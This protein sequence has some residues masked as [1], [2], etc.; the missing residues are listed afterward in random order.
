VLASSQAVCKSCGMAVSERTCTRASTRRKSR[1]PANAASMVPGSTVSVVQRSP[2]ASSS[3]RCGVR[4]ATF[5]ACV[6]GASVASS[7]SAGCAGTDV[8][9]GAITSTLWSSAETL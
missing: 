2:L 9:P 3:T 6:S 1:N 5:G 7:N 4:P 8:S